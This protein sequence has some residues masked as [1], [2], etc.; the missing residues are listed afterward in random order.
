[1]TL[2]NF[3]SKMLLKS[4]LKIKIELQHVIK[5]NLT[6]FWVRNDFYLTKA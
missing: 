4:Y 5:K 3:A 1:M 6:W 2:E